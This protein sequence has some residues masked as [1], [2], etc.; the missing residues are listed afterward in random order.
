MPRR[1]RS[2]KRWTVDP[3]TF[4]LGPIDSRWQGLTDEERADVLSQIE[5]AWRDEGWRVLEGYRERRPGERPWA[6]WEFDADEEHPTDTYEL[7]R[8]IELDA[9]DETELRAVIAIADEIV[10]EQAAGRIQYL[11]A[12]QHVHNGNTARRHLGMPEVETDDFG[13]LH[14]GRR[15]LD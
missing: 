4:A 13:S 5:R 10:A 3:F 9:I 1:R 15:N 11:E 6:W 2:R 14:Y 8:L 7:E 12:P